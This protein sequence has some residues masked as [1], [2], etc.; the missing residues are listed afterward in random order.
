MAASRR[1]LVGKTI[2][3]IHRNA[4]V[5]VSSISTTF[6]TI[7]SYPS[8]IL[9]LRFTKT[10]PSPRLQLHSYS[11]SAALDNLT[12]SVEA[13]D[14]HPWPEWVAFV[15]RLKSKG[16][17]D[18]ASP[19]GDEGGSV[20]S[21]AT[22]FGTTRKDLNRMRNGCLSFARD[23]FD[24][25]KPGKQKRSLSRTDIQTVVER[26]CPSLFRKAVNSAKR[27][28]AFV[29]LDEGDVCSACN[30]RGSCDR[31]YVILKESE[32]A[33]R[34]VDI[35]RML[36]IYALDPLVL[37]GGEK[38]HGREHIETSARKLLSELIE[39]SDTSLDPALP[40]P[41]VKPPRQKEQSEKVMD[42][43]QSQNVEM[44]RGDWMCSNVMLEYPFFP[45]I[46]RVV[47][48][49]HSV[50]LLRS[51]SLLVLTIVVILAFVK[52]I[53]ANSPVMAFLVL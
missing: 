29:R 46:A 19:S 32:E 38:P 45:K 11:S 47:S 26:G 25:F 18:E 41:A 6:L 10:S 43:G 1:L 21:D 8:T 51:M 31:A 27:L 52:S 20:A 17:F 33:A 22:V 42:R 39:L 35:V 23:R 2:F 30:L 5:T 49:L 48:F 50:L 9:S 4:P 28:R 13:T 15:E 44:K 14:S 12:D 37:S 53:I 36:L 3:R 16:Y 40:K 24:I 7:P 34:T